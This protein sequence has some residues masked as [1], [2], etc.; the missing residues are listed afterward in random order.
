M[1]HWLLSMSPAVTILEINDEMYLSRKENQMK[2]QNEGNGIEMNACRVKNISRK[3]TL[4]ELNEKRQETRGSNSKKK[5]EATMKT[6]W[7]KGEKE[8]CN[9]NANQK[10]Q[11]E[12]S[13][14]VVKSVLASILAS[15]LQ[16]I[17]AS[18]L[19]SVQRVS[20]LFLIHLPFL[21]HDNS[22]NQ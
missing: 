2:E 17:L 12:C 1:Y 19:A 8:N 16:S 21:F 20:C 13:L 5:K 22:I 4:L 6:N 7:V 3:N 18:I 15:L 11:Q 9:Q 10:Q 14:F